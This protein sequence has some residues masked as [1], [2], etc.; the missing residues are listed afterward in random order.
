MYTIVSADGL[1]AHVEVSASAPMF[2]DC[3]TGAGMHE[4]RLLRLPQNVSVTLQ[5]D[6]TRVLFSLVFFFLSS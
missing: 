5:T 4:M 1:V 6:G 3:L 2:V